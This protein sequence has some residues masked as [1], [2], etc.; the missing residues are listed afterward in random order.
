MM[1]FRR[2]REP[3][4]RI[5]IESKVFI[6]PRRIFK[7]SPLMPNGGK[8]HGLRGQAMD[9]RLDFR[10]PVFKRAW[11]RV[12]GGCPCAKSIWRGRRMPAGA[13][14]WLWAW[15]GGPGRGA[16]SGSP[17]GWGQP[18]IAVYSSNAKESSNLKTKISWINN[19]ANERIMSVPSYPLAVLG[20]WSMAM[21]SGMRGGWDMPSYQGWG[22]LA[23]LIKPQDERV[24]AASC[25]K[26]ARRFQFLNANLTASAYWTLIPTALMRCWT[27]HSPSRTRPALPRRATLAYSH[28]PMCNYLFD[29]RFLKKSSL[30]WHIP[31][32]LT[33]QC[34]ARRVCI[35]QHKLIIAA[36]YFRALQAFFNFSWQP[37]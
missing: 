31:L 11:W 1:P 21:W 8:A 22:R 7:Y 23:S 18:P 20:S 29:L 9:K 16:A 36:F 4:K 3:I 19:S 27:F 30:V 34:Q 35:H 13:Q 17:S 37:W 10:I 28:L 6:G 14:G 24:D 12:E 2:G 33:L 25:R 32:N 26:Y 5:Q 15:S